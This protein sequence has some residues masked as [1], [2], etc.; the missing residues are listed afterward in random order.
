MTRVSTGDM[1]AF[2]ALVE[3]HQALVA[4]TVGRMLG[5]NSDVEDVAQAFDVG[6]KQR[7]GIPQ[8]GSGIDDAVENHVAANH[9]GPQGI[10]VEDV[11]VVPL[12]RKALDATQIARSSRQN[13]DIV[14]RR[15]QPARSDPDMAPHRP[16]AAAADDTTASTAA[17]SAWA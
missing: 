13:S 17:A 11:T 5:H 2:E 15:N 3:R 14:S 8:P 16:P 12:H 10:F 1:A 4:G 7:G 6:P 9:R